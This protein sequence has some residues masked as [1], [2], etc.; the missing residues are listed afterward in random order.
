MEGASQ[1]LNKLKSIE[2]K[3]KEMES[4]VGYT[5]SYAMPIHERAGGK[6]LENPIKEMLNDGT[7]K[8]TLRNKSVSLDTVK[9]GLKACAEA[10]YIKSQEIVP[11]KTGYLKSSGYYR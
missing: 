1:L 4:E 7:L 2:L 9:D 3:L 11:V 5:A 10:I 8:T 6:F